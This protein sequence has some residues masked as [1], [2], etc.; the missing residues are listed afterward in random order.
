MH[1]HVVVGTEPPVKL[2]FR[3]GSPQDR[4]VQKPV[5]LE[6]VGKPADVHASPLAEGIRCQL[7]FLILLTDYSRTVEREDILFAFPK[8][9]IAF[10]VLRNKM[11]LLMMLI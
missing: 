5:V 1:F 9:N 6:A 8:I 11:L 4:P 3:A 2:I 7:Y 10:A